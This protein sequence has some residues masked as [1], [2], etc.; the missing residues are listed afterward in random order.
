MIVLHQFA[1]SWG[2][3]NQ[4]Q[5][6]VKTETY[7]RMARLPYQIVE[8][9]PL[10]GPRGKLPFIV[11]QGQKISD[12]SLIEL[13]LKTTYG[14]P[15]DAHLSQTEK[16]VAKAFQRLLEEHLYW[17]GMMTRWNGTAENWQTTK[18][19]IF[20]VLPPVARDIA[21][22]VYH[23]RI[24][25]QL[26]GHGLGRLS[27]EEAFKLGTEDLDALSAFLGDKP[28][29]MGAQPSSLDAS[30]YGILVNTLGCPIASPLKD[31][32]LGK[33]NLLAYCQRMQGEYFPELPWLHN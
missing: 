16:G 8:S 2:I 5:F 28:Y 24:N 6:C 26:I 32:A 21:A 27:Q 10:H 18:Q 13:H 20:N 9:L 7:L 17:A 11:D 14:D 22:V 31:Y 1:R 23:R 19:A 30:A 4:S 33:A 15:L 12:S 3:P 29:F 25:S